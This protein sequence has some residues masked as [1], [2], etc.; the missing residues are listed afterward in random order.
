M[1]P[2]LATATG[3]TPQVLDD[4]LLQ[5]LLQSLQTIS[6]E[7]IDQ[8]LPRL[9]G[10]LEPWTGIANTQP[11]IFE[12]QVRFRNRIYFELGRGRNK[13]KID[14]IENGTTINSL[15]L[16]DLDFSRLPSFSMIVPRF[17]FGLSMVLSSVV[18]PILNG[19]D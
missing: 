11:R 1:A 9:M 7:T 2:I 19:K 18:F 6:I 3:F 17:D 10:L 5:E 16:Y 15:L 4:L 8:E 14:F 13:K 12:E